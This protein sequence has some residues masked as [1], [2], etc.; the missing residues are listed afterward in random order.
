[1]SRRRRDVSEII[2]SWLCKDYCSILTTHDPKPR[3]AEI[4]SAAEKQRSEATN[5]NQLNS[6]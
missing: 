5:A 1:M 2:V 6:L 3:T 4:D